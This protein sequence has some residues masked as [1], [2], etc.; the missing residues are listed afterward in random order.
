M[1]EVVIGIDIGGT[2]TKLGAVDEIGNVLMKEV[3]STKSHNNEQ[4]FLS[5]LSRTIETMISNL[6]SDFDVKGI[7]V[8]APG[9]NYYT[10]IIENPS[11]L[12]WNQ[13]VHLRQYLK[14]QH[15][16]PVIVTN[17]ANLAAVGE[18]TFG[19]AR[20]MKDFIVISLGTG[21]GSGIVCNG[22]IIHGCDGLA[23]ELGHLI[24]KVNGRLQ[25]RNHCFD[26]AG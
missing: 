20:D 26:S 25:I 14:D 12:R 6:G 4:S 23:G 10:G 16:L 3:I 11:N 2:T 21:L 13:E 7:G 17:D 19:E 1:K 24:V 18:M 9:A 22:E 5:S 8:G 15:R